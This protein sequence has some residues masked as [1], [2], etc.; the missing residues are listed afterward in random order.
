VPAGLAAPEAWRLWVDVLGAQ[1]IEVSRS[2]G[3]ALA[4]QTH[5]AHGVCEDGWMVPAQPWEGVAV[6]ALLGY[7]GVQPP[8]VFSRCMQAT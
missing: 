7:A 4:A 8:R 2:E 6:A 1:P 5:T 3:E